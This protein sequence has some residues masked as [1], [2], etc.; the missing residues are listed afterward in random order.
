MGEKCI[1][2]QGSIIVG[3]LT[4]RCRNGPVGK[5]LKLLRTRYHE[6]RAKASAQDTSPVATFV[7]EILS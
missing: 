7:P 1:W 3:S 6:T 4:P 2:G 5:A